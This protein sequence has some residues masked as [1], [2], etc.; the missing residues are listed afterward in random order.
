MLRLQSRRIGHE[1]ECERQLSFDVFE[2]AETYRWPGDKI[3]SY[4]GGWYQYFIDLWGPYMTD[5][6]I[7]NKRWEEIAPELRPLSESLLATGEI[8][9]A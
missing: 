4:W 3:G 8:P 5:L 6:L 9:T 2:N 7:G 1:Q